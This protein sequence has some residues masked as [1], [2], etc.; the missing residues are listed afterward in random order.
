MKLSLCTQRR[1]AREPLHVRNRP[2][3]GSLEIEKQRENPGSDKISPN[4]RVASDISNGQSRGF[5]PFASAAAPVANC[6]GRSAKCP[7]PVIE[8]VKEK[9]EGAGRIRN[10]E[11][12]E[13]RARGSTVRLR[14]V[15]DDTGP[16]EPGGRAGCGSEGGLAAGKRLFSFRNNG[17]DERARDSARALFAARLL[18]NELQRP[19]RP[20]TTRRKRKKNRTEEARPRYSGPCGERSPVS[21]E[22]RSWP[23]I[24]VPEEVSAR[25]DSSLPLFGVRRSRR[26][27]VSSRYVPSA[28]RGGGS[29]RLMNSA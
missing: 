9:R 4:K 11:A 7:F 5:R 10:A 25:H 27:C 19:G 2:S 8:N 18:G 26:G 28:D 23:A 15:N 6:R 22:Y 14:N 13:E 16:D 24:M 29:R 21:R 1:N 3:R 17:R 20:T 12:V